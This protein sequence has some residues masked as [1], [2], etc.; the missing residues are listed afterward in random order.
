MEDDIQFTLENEEHGTLPFLDVLIIKCG[1]DVKYKVH[2]KKTNQE[3]YIHFLSAHSDRIKSGVVIGFFLRAI[4]ICSEEY[5]DEEV[6][7]IFE[8]FMK[9]MYPK[10]FLIRCLQKA[11]KIRCSSKSSNSVRNRSPQKV[12]VVPSNSKTSHISK[13]L[14]SAGVKIVEKAGIKIGDMIKNK[15][16]DKTCQD[17]I[18]YKVPCSGCSKSYLGE[19]HRGL[20]KRTQEHRRD[21]KNHK[22]TSSFVIHIDQCQHLPEWDKSEILWCGEGRRRR[23]IME[24]AVIETLPNIN[25]KRGDYAL[26]SILASMIWSDAHIMSRDM[27]G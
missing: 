20:K 25:S 9:L 11:K 2:R 10:A 7:H 8:I 27:Q 5:L 21:I 23:K 1:N 19:T 6:K 24:S 12:L 17:S 22:S 16:K 14:K 3:D 4:R 26:S 18:V 15:N 13:L